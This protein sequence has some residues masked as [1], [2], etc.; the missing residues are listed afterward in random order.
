MTRLLLTAAACLAALGVAAATGGAAGSKTVPYTA[1]LRASAEVPPIK[2]PQAGGSF[3]GIYNTQTKMLSWTL[4]FHG[5]TGA[6]TAAHI[7]TGVA[8]EKG[9]VLVPLCGP[10]KSGQKGNALIGAGGAGLYLKAYVNV[11]TEANPD[12]E[13]RGQLRRPKSP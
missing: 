6:A 11:H 4:R 8:G 12:G 2:R 13:I 5:L 7:H 3:T 10:C 1:T 9:P